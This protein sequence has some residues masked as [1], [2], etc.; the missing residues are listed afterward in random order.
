MT[1]DETSWPPAAPEPIGTSVIFPV[2]MVIL[3]V[4]LSITQ[5]RLITR[6]R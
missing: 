2:T 6:Q 4:Y 1:P 5:D 3:A